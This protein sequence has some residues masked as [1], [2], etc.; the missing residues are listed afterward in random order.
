MPSCMLVR[1]RWARP[2]PRCPASSEII[3]RHGHGILV[4]PWGIRALPQEGPYQGL[5]ATICLV[6]W[7]FPTA[8]HFMWL[9][10][11]FDGFLNRKHTLGALSF[12]RSVGQPEPLTPSSAS[13]A[14]RVETLR[15]LDSDP[16]RRAILGDTP[17]APGSPGVVVWEMRNWGCRDFPKSPFC[18]PTGGKWRGGGAQS[19]HAHKSRLCAGVIPYVTET[20]IKVISK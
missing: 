11:E 14:T 20:L 4:L 8:Y 16:P 15:G 18:P 2:S 10:L 6:P 1:G 13:G 3:G 17:S 12:H 7:A 19:W 9:S 5:S